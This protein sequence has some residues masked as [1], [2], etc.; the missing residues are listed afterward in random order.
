MPEQS[1]VA[2]TRLER[3]KQRTRA[4]LIEAAQGFIAAGKLNVAILD[5]T[6]AADVG[7]GSFY[8][9][10]E[11]KE[12]LFAAAVAEVLDAHGALLDELTES[13]DDPAETFACRFR[14]TGR[15]FRMRPLESEIIL[16]NAMTL[17]SSDRGLAPR[18]AR[19]QGGH[20]GGTVSDRG[21]TTRPRGGRRGFARPRKPPARRTQPRRRRNHR[22][23]HP[24]HPA[25]LRPYD[26]R[27]GQDLPT[28]PSQTR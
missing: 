27:G 9:H 19:H 26:T 2:A 24:R 10:F 22:R 5:I 28:S 15:L 21:P 13:I 23:V 6:Q 14:L 7:M 8:N 3:R 18:A 4:A 11:T 12:Q 16:N 20:S 25:S 17:L 1:H